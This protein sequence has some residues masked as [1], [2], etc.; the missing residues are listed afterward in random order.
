MDAKAPSRRD[1]L[2]IAGIGVVALATRAS[3]QDSRPAN[4]KRAI[5]VAHLTDMHVQPELKADQGLAA[6]LRHVQAQSDKPELILTGGDTVMDSF[7][8]EEARTRLQWDLWKKVIKGECSLPIE[9]CLGNHDVWGWNKKKSGTTGEEVLYGKK[10]ALDQFGVAR[11]YRNFDRAGWHFVILDSIQPRGGGYTARLDDE[12]FDWL[13]ADLRATN[14]DTPVLILSHIPILSVAALAGDNRTKKGD[15]EIP[16]SILHTDAKKLK[17][18]FVNHPNVKLCLS[19]HLHLVD[20]C[21]YLG[22]TYLCNGAVCGGWWKGPHQETEPGYALLDLY[23]DGTF[24]NQYI[25]YGW[26]AA[27]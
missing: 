17:D 7:E 3:A 13:S 11:S 23:S 2:A 6:C 18:L 5:R 12:Q 16:G 4:R 8:A 19:G 22:V 25:R 20:R 15:W 9:S 10:W 26:K 24:E 14:R 21:E 1:F 27:T